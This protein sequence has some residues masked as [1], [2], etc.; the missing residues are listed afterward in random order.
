M[1]TILNNHISNGNY[2]TNYNNYKNTI[3]TAVLNDTKKLFSYSQC[4]NALNT[5]YS[6]GSY[7]VPGIQTLMT[8]RQTYLSGTTEFTA[9]TP[10]IGN[11]IISN[12]TT[13]NGN[14]ILNINITNASLV[15]FN[16][17]YKNK[18]AFTKIQLFDDGMHNDGIAG[19]NNYG[20]SLTLKNYSFE[21]YV[22]AEN[23]DAG[24]FSPEEA[25]YQFH[26]YNVYPSADVNNI[27]INEFLSDNESDVKNEYH[28]NADWIEIYNKTNTSIDLSNAYLSNSVNK[29]A[30]YCFPNGTTIAPFGYITVWADEMNL[31]NATQF[32][33]NFKL[34]K[35]G[36]ELVFSNGLNKTFDNF[37]F[38]NQTTDKSIGRCA[39]GI[40]GFQELIYPT[41][42]FRNCFVGM[43][44]NRIENNNIQVYPNP[45]NQVITV[46]VNGTQNIEIV[47]ILGK[48][49]LQDVIT[50]TKT[51]TINNLPN[52]VFIVKSKY[53][54][55]KFIHIQ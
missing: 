37:T 43:N 7:S 3:D 45:A 42:G 48:I 9:S 53:A 19:D 18:E 28:I 8:P 6:V 46:K 38:A 49:L 29:K 27:V 11:M 55:S 34:D 35:D 4:T 36:D 20:N 22:Y 25:E 39:D 32:H 44:E 24:K 12:A 1:R 23:T 41:F 2:L 21:Y 50:D 33:A 26:K 16:Y 47:D 31:P 52:G 30:K 15:E 5:N 51:I 13:L 54:Q 17:R 10:S 14:M 40:G